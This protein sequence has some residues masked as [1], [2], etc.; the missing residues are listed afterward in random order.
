MLKSKSI[1]KLIE[2][3][4]N[5]INADEQFKI[6]DSVG[7]YKGSEINGIL[8]QG[9]STITPIMNYINATVPYT[10]E[11]VV[12]YQC[13]E[14]RAD[15]IVN[16]VNS[17]I[18]NLNGKIKVVNSGKAIFLFDT[19]DLNDYETR[20]TVGSSARLGVTF[21]VN[22]SN[23]DVGTKYEMA[24]LNN[25]FAGTINTRYFDSQEEQ[26]QWYYKKITNAPFSELL[27][28]NVNSLIITQQRYI[29][30]IGTDTN[31]LL[32]YNYAIIRETKEDGTI[33]HYYYDITNANVDQYNILSVDLKMDTLQTWYFNPNIQFDDCFIA[34]A[35][36]D[37]FRKN[38]EV[39]TGSQLR[40]TFDFT[41]RSNLFKKENILNVAK[42]PVEK[43]KLSPLIDTSGYGTDINE[44]FRE[45]VSHWVYYYISGGKD[46]KFYSFVG[47]T[48]PKE[49][50]LPNIK[51]DIND[52]SQVDGGMVVLVAPVYKTDKVIKV[53][54]KAEETEQNFYI[55]WT[56][57]AI[58]RFL[59]MQ[60]STGENNGFANVYAIKNSIMPP[61]T[62]ENMFVFMTEDKDGNLELEDSNFNNETGIASFRS[63]VAFLTPDNKTQTD[64]TSNRYACGY[65]LKQSLTAGLSMEIENN[66]FQSRFTKEEIKSGKSGNWING[67]EPKLLNEDYS[68]YRLFFGGNTYDLPVSKTSRKPSFIYKEILSPEVTKA[69]LIY[70]PDKSIDSSNVFSDITK[71]DFTGFVINIDLS[72][73]FSTDRL[74]EFLATNKN[75]L[76]ILNNTQENAITNSV[77]SMIGGVATSLITGGLSEISGSGIIGSALS[78]GN[79]LNNQNLE[80]TNMALTYDN[81]AQSPE[82]LS[83]L[84][85]NALLIQSVSD[86]AIYIELQMPLTTEQKEI[87]NHLKLNG[88]VLNDVAKITDYDNK[89]ISFNYIEA[90]VTGISGVVISNT[91][92]DDIRQRFAGGVRFWNMND[93]NE[94]VISYEKENYE[95]WLEG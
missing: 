4:L 63:T 8:K 66:M 9:K 35:H 64:F 59:K 58:K 73:W 5:S 54:G 75:N 15:G 70:D 40:Y 82:T 32:M 13:G 69:M 62:P 86:L 47:S 67:I 78:F 81:M 56:E 85:S 44:W 25:D 46:Y 83:S 26:Y 72:M 42:R 87:I 60:D 74:D 1:A 76:Q 29:N 51:Y 61:F 34:R 80:K 31:E 52:V 11:I 2:N 94:F 21:V 17:F 48:Q 22:Y 65:M 92:R 18:K 3:E 68:T 53:P 84:N 12:P 77:V 27:T 89:R 49:Y 20:A 19:I 39:G 50:E 24:L 41:E 33:N 30:E 55:T 36:Q 10:L 45:N 37:R 23:K 88:Y 43:K 93:A 91:I 71:S 6:L 16:I 28:P 57:I 95:R 79:M 14:D 7:D 90:Q 38:P